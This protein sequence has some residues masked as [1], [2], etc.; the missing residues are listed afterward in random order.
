MR[1]RSDAYSSIHKHKKTQI[2]RTQSAHPGALAVA[3][4]PSSILCCSFLNRRVRVSVRHIVKSV[5]FFSGARVREALTA[6]VLHE[7]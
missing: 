1:F 7:R 2:P 4:I 6:Y 5:S 3:S